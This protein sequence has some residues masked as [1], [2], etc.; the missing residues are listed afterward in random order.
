MGLFLADTLKNTLNV[1]CYKSN[2]IIRISTSFILN[3]FIFLLGKRCC[4]VG[5]R[6]S[7]RQRFLP[8]LY[9]LQRTL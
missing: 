1:F 4:I 6:R 7:V 8:F 3:Y 5:S 2:R 9:I